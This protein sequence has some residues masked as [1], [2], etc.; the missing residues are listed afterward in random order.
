ME[1]TGNTPESRPIT[2]VTEAAT[3]PTG[4][5]VPMTLRDGLIL[6]AI[7]G[8]LALMFFVSRH[9][10]DERVP[11]GSPEHAAFIEQ[12]VA[13]CLE[14]QWTWTAEHTDGSRDPRPLTERE[15]GCRQLVIQS[16]RFDPSARPTRHK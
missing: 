14:K 5:S 11:T 1:P 9:S 10:R 16:D 13:E 12:L 8:G 4:K 6:T 15:A 2:A 3:S 7:V